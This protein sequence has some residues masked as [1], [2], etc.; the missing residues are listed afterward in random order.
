[1]LFVTY[2][3]YRGFFI[4]VPAV[5]KEVQAKL[6]QGLVEAEN[7]LNADLDPSTG[8]LRP[9]SQL[10]I[11]VGAGLVTMA[12]TVKMLASY[13]FYTVKKIADFLKNGKTTGASSAPT[14]QVRVMIRMMK[15]PPPVDP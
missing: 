8:K 13:S 11:N 7:E 10:L 5:F 9:R 6:R 15:P 12:Y 1:M 14:T 2:R 3:A 4:I